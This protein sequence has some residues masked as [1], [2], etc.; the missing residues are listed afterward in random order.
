VETCYFCGATE[1]LEAYTHHGV[2]GFACADAV[3]CMER[4]ERMVKMLTARRTPDT[5]QRG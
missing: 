4:M 2:E 5:A 3:A 1:G